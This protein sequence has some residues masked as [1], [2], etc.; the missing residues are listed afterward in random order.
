[1][2]AGLCILIPR[3][4]AYW[5]RALEDGIQCIKYNPND[6][7]DLYDR[8]DFI[9]QKP[10]IARTIGLNAKQFAGRYKAETIYAHIHAALT[11]NSCHLQTMGVKA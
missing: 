6:S 1:M 7:N 8:L 4:K 10:V 2:A 11:G 9:T 5:D 3:D